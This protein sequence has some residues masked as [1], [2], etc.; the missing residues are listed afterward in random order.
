MTK[1][2]EKKDAANK[3]YYLSKVN[4]LIEIK[5]LLNWNNYFKMSIES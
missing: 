2:K 4:N 3:L 5:F 1:K